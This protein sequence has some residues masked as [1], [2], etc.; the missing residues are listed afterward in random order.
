MSSEKN[1]NTIF[2][3]NLSTDEIIKGPNTALR[4]PVNDLACVEIKGEQA[5]TLLQGQLTCDVTALEHGENTFG[6]FCNPKGRIRCFFNIQAVSEGFLLFM[7][8]DTVERFIEDLGKYA[9]FYK[10]TINRLVDYPMSAL[11][12][13]SSTENQKIRQYWQGASNPMP[14]KPVL[15]G[16]NALLFHGVEACEFASREFSNIPSGEPEFWQLA[17][18]QAK[19]P[20]LSLTQSEQFLPHDIGLIALGAINFKKGCYTGQEII[21][22]MQYLGKL[23]KSLFL[24]RCTGA[25]SAPGS[26]IEGNGK[27]VGEIINSLKINDNLSLSLAMLNAEHSSSTLTLKSEKQPILEVVREDTV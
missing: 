23:K 11:L 16:T 21:A 14:A 17:L 12:F 13:A 8:D 1:T 19:I 9:V 20:S 2:L 22:R 27:N 26:A 18:F 25:P 3:S 24:L 10:A 6:A 5:E 4:V 15:Y 7:P